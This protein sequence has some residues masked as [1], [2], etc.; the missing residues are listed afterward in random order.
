MI[1]FVDKIKSV[2]DPLEP[3]RPASSLA[4][5]SVAA[6]VIVPVVVNEE[7]LDSCEILF[8]LRTNRVKNHKGQV[9][10]PGGVFES[11]DENLVH[12][13]KRETWEETGIDP[14]SYAVAGA[15]LPYDTVTG[16]RI[17]PFVGLFDHRPALCL[18]KIEIERAFFVPVRFF[19]DTTNISEHSI[20][21][22]GKQLQM[23]AFVWEGM[24]IWGAT[25][26]ILMDMTQRLRQIEW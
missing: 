22:E 3:V 8:T 11:G 9:S 19:L 18:N 13:A 1:S 16:Y 24:V 4:S 6:A 23:K 15:I 14:S 7:R 21:W 2:L 26:N 20:E 12:T 17:Y 5:H 25:F 10:F